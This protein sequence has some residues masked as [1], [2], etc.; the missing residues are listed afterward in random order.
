[1][2]QTKANFGPKQPPV[3]IR[4]CFGDRTVTFERTTLSDPALSGI[5]NHSTAA[6]EMWLALEEY[7]EEGATAK[8]LAEA[9][10]QPLKTVKNKLSLLRTNQRAE[11]L[12]KGLW[13]A[14]G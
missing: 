4:T 8:K 11:N 3:A 9:L 12:G 2:T 14:I 6:D 5:E 13:R 7:G 10:V 1:M